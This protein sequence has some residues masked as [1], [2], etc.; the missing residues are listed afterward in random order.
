MHLQ[1]YSVKSPY[2]S[3]FVNRREEAVT[4]AL[5]LP[6]HFVSNA[7]AWSCVV[8]QKICRHVLYM[9]AYCAIMSPEGCRAG[10]GRGVL[11]RE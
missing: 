10:G 2:Q 8:H 11:Y 5:N 3:P 6:V 7:V 9:G 4:T 1:S